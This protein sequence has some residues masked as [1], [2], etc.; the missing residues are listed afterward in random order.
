MCTKLNSYNIRVIHDC[1]MQSRQ[2]AESGA[3]DVIDNFDVK[4]WHRCSWE[5][6]SNS[7]HQQHNHKVTPFTLKNAYAIKNWLV[8]TLEL[9]PW[10]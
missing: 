1:I 2:W 9:R 7:S 3:V 10:F 5:H 8:F 6:V 4:S